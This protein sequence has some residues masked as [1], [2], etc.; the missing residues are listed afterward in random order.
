M[1]KLRTIRLA[2]FVVLIVATGA[3]EQG[4]R[5][6]L[7]NEPSRD[8]LAEYAALLDTH[9]KAYPRRFT[10][11]KDVRV[12]KVFGIDVSHYQGN[13]VWEKVSNQGI[14][15]V[16]MKATQGEQFYDPTFE[17]NWGEVAKI[18]VKDPSLHRGAYHFMTADGSA[19][20]QAQ[21]F[22]STVGSLKANDLPPCLDLEWDWQTKNG[23]YVRD[24]QGHKIDGWANLKS[25]VIVERVSKW[26]QIVERETGKKPIIYTVSSWWTKRIGRDSPLSGY[27]FWI[28]D[29]TSKSLGKEDP[30]VP[31]RL[32]WSF[33]QLTNQGVL[34]KG[35]ISNPVDTT[36]FYG[37]AEDL[38]KRF[39]FK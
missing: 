13:I 17:R 11:P 5:K 4:K 38:D 32:S 31:E 22:V 9:T 25:P 7:Q 30:K 15:F 14:R 35:G 29:Y 33:W 39:G 24:K 8:D 6:P 3:A 2:V 19:D 10:F 28:A 20:L 26:L 12:D 34:S 27:V 21:N 1:G 23:R 37:D 16:Y 36:V 18:E